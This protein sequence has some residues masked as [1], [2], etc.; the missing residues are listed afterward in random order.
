[1]FDYQLG[2]IQRRDQMRVASILTTLDWHK[3]GQKQHQGKRTV[4]WIPKTPLKDKV[5]NEV[6]RPQNQ[7]N[8]GLSI[9]TIPTTP[10]KEQTNEEILLETVSK[11]QSQ[12][13][14]EGIEQNKKQLIKQT[15][16]EV[17]RIGW[18]KKQAIATVKQR[19]GVSDAFG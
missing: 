5:L 15:T 12:I 8:K 2:Q 16:K 6:L 1:M 17:R 9:P 11:N 18:G 10:N 14:N 4:I 3:A 13:Q 19:Y 7:S